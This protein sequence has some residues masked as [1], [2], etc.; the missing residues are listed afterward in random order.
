MLDRPFDDFTRNP[1]GPFRFRCEK[2]M[3]DLNIQAIAV[4][5]YFELA[6]LPL[7]DLHAW[8]RAEHSSE[9]CLTVQPQ[10]WQTCN[11]RFSFSPLSLWASTCAPMFVSCNKAERRTSSAGWLPRTE[12]SRFRAPFASGSMNTPKPRNSPSPTEVTTH[13]WAKKPT[14]STLRTPSSFNQSSSPFAEKAP[15]TSFVKRRSDFDCGPI[16]G[17]NCEPHVPGTKAFDSCGLLKCWTQAIGHPASR[18]SSTCRA[19]RRSAS[20]WFGTARNPLP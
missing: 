20:S 6:A 19:I 11:S 10:V 12:C 8:I 18:A 4:G 14:I 2:I 13:M 15:Y 3:D 9:H 5:G 7:N 17:G 16:P 1:S